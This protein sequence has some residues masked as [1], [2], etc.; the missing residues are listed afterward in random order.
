M[1]K[2]SE[3]ELLE[4]I[5]NSDN[6]V[7]RYMYTLYFPMIR[8]LVI[9]NSGNI[10]DAE[11]VF[12]DAVV[13]IY[14][15]LLNDMLTLT[16]TLKTYM[17]GVCRNLWLQQLTK[18]KRTNFIDEDEIEKAIT[19]TNDEIQDFNEEKLFQLHYSRLNPTCKEILELYFNKVPYKEIAVK[20]SLTVSNVK[21]SKFRCKEMLFRNIKND[22]R[23]GV[24]QK[25]R[26]QVKQLIRV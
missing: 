4:G 25:Q 2:F 15:K 7:L 17:Y 18:R 11:D 6:N 26:K 12:Q 24:L 19:V 20:L 10:I 21:T 13:I 5:K 23:Y 1:V 9:N 16:C 3:K 14:E 8:K 22:P